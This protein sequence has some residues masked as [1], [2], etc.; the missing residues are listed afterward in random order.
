MSQI[1]FELCFHQKYNKSFKFSLGKVLKL[2][3]SGAPFDLPGDSAAG[4]PGKA[5]P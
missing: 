1:K 2:K 3:K 5:L 4:L